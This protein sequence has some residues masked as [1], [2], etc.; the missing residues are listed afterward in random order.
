MQI[1]CEDEDL[2]QGIYKIRGPNQ[3]ALAICW[4]RM[5]A[6]NKIPRFEDFDPELPIHDPKR[7]AV[8]NVERCNGQFV[9]RALYSGRFLNEPFGSAWSGKTLEEVTPPSL[10]SDI[11]RGAHECVRTGCVI[12]MILRT[13]NGK[14]HAI[15]LE[16]LLL[17]FGRSGKVE[18]IVASLQLTSLENA[19]DRKTI[20]HEFEA[21][22][23]CVLSVRIP[24]VE[25]VKRRPLAA[26]WIP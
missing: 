4:T 15:D 5:E 22:S 26:T 10:R 3:Q 19:V 16:R 9:L 25:T 8:W 12:Y 7:L 17:P 2:D 21:Q 1:I 6:E 20:V 11:V 18:Q 23:K 14:G 13:R 24:R